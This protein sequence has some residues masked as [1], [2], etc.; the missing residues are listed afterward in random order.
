M[1]VVSLGLTQ[2]S[3]LPPLHFTASRLI[4]DCSITVT[5]AC[6]QL[7]WVGEADGADELS[8]KDQATPCPDCYDNPY[9]THL[10]LHSSN[11]I[12]A[13]ATPNLGH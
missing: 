5:H 8:W 6:W 12:T 10:L 11:P 13:A 1:P 3:F 9:N 2:T 4:P 7:L